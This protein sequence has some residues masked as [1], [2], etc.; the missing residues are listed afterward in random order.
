M[1]VLETNSAEETKSLARR[2]G[3]LLHDPVR[4]ALNGPLGAG[5]TVFAQG[6]AAG[7]GIGEPVTSPTFILIKSYQGRLSLHHCDWYRLS[8][9]DDVA[10]S[11]F[12]DLELT[13]GI[14]IVEWADK[15]DRMLDRP[16]LQVRLK[17]S[18][19]QSRQLEFSVSGKSPMLRDLIE[20]LQ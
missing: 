13:P 11:G 6:V 8:S 20:S 7:L 9:T 4:I 16:F 19:E 12:D 3:Q 18:G 17:H 5:K 1:L 2:L 14:V 10:S 15:F